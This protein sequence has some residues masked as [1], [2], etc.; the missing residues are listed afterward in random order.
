MGPPCL[1]GRREARRGRGQVIAAFPAQP[2]HRLLA[3]CAV[4]QARTPA[5]VCRSC[6]P[7]SVEPWKGVRRPNKRKQM[8]IKPRK[9]AWISLDSFGRIGTF[10][11]VTT[12]P[13]KK[14]LPMSH[15]GS[16]ATC[17]LPLW[18]LGRHL[19]GGSIPRLE[20]YSTKLRFFQTNA[21]FRFAAGRAPPGRAFA[22]SYGIERRAERKAP[23]MNI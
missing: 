23:I 10:Q 8:Q 15:C 22:P 5:S 13:N 3:C 18:S 4:A 14:I 21:Y 7:S 9:K 11:W 17:F 1:T 2:S 20:R 6:A 12:N 16:T 19:E